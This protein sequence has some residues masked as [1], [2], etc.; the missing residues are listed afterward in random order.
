MLAEFPDDVVSSACSRSTTEQQKVRTEDKQG[1]A[2]GT[3]PR[4]SHTLTSNKE[5]TP[6]SLRMVRESYVPDSFIS[7]SSSRKHKE[8]LHRKVAH[9][10]DG[11]VQH[12]LNMF[13][14]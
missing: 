4:E 2:Y 5:R 10:L 6:A 11:V 9:A 1:Q 14:F 7:K 13:S 12:P 3:Q 8:T